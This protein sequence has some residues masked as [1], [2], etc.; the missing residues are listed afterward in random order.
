M[1]LLATPI[2]IQEMILAV[3]LIIK[4]ST[5]DFESPVGLTPP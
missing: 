2:A 4:D 5:P 3:W 1:G